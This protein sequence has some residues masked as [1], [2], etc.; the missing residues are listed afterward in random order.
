MIAAGVLVPV[1]L[2]KE[3]LSMIL[4]KKGTSWSKGLQPSFSQYH[5]PAER[6]KG[7]I[8]QIDTDL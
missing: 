5:L 3:R 8:M 4:L 6:G 7:G 2:M 1:S